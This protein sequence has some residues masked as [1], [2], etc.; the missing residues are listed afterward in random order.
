MGGQQ[1][2]EKDALRLSS[3]GTETGKE[4]VKDPLISS[5]PGIYA[6]SGF[7]IID[8]LVCLF[9]A[10]SCS[11]LGFCFLYSRRLVNAFKLP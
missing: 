6:P 7:G 4:V 11:Y 3:A 2:F 10:F 5:I 1:N 8:I 9:L